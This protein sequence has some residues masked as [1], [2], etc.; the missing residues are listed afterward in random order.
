MSINSLANA[1]AA[2]RTD[3]G[4]DE[5]PQNRSEIAAAAATPPENTPATKQQA[6]GVSTAL[7]V[8]FGYIPTEVVTLY[9]AVA[10]ALQPAAAAGTDTV[11]AGAAGGSAV[12]AGAAAAGAGATAVASASPAALWIAF[13]CFFVATP[14]TV[15]VVYASKLK[16]AGKPLP[17]SYATWPLW[18]MIAAL[19]AFCAWAFALPNTP[20]RD[21]PWYSPALASISVL[22]ASTLLGLLAPLFQRPLGPDPAKD[23]T[24]QAGVATDPAQP[25]TNPV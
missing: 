13:W 17:V 20:F 12:G 15:W 16:A 3:I 5:P 11:G 18:E 22:L 2:R 14:L 24:V 21:Y 25:D 6:S 7:N 19:I 9:V 23:R 1:A 8:V 4:S 10:A